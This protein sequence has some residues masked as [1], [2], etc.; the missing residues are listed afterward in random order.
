M[1]AILQHESKEKPVS[2]SEKLLLTV[3]WDRS[4]MAR[5]ELFSGD[6]AKLYLEDQDMLD[7]ALEQALMRN[8]VA[9]T[10]LLVDSGARIT[11]LDLPKIYEASGCWPFITAFL[12]RSPNMQS[13]YQG[14]T[15][16][17]FTAEGLKNDIVIRNY[18]LLIWAACAYRPKMA[19]YFLTKVTNP[20][21]G[22]LLCALIWRQCARKAPG[23][24][25]DQE[26]RER[27]RGDAQELETYACQNVSALFESETEKDDESK[28]KEILLAELPAPWKKNTT[29]L[30]L[31]VTAECKKFMSERGVQAALEARWTGAKIS[32]ISGE[33]F[34]EK[35]RRQ[36]LAPRIKFFIH[37]LEYLIFLFLFSFVTLNT[38]FGALSVSE[39]FLVWWMLSR[40]LAE[41][42]EFVF[43]HVL[44][45]EQVFWNALDVSAI[46]LYW[47][48]LGYR[49]HEAEDLAQAIMSVATVL[50]FV[51]FLERGRVSARFGHLIVTIEEVSSL[52]LCLRASETR[53]SGPPAAATPSPGSSSACICRFSAK[54]MEP[55]MSATTAP[56]SSSHCFCLEVS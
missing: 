31:A 1:R 43:E 30:E 46:V 13:L 19:Q 6:K 26:L 37:T 47:V 49:T 3:V 9:M 29:L 5:N 33:T 17:L 10:K 45:R 23:D 21:A 15:S 28:T 50:V 18:E 32:K 51:R 8:K 34:F 54:Y 56:L 36:S 41:I 22:A 12:G 16:G 4:D 35:W 48:A 24:S 42:K 7:M 53:S 20:I 52:C 25:M 39:S 55:T 38:G 27:V 40:S 2:A 14:V 11:H 44:Y